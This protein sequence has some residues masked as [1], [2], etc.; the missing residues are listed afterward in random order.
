MGGT[1]AQ[2][3]VRSSA[4]RAPWRTGS[5]SASAAGPLLQVGLAGARPLLGGGV[6][7]AAAGPGPRS[8]GFDPD[9]YELDPEDIYDPDEYEHGFAAE[10]SAPR[11]Q[12][13]AAVAAAASA[14]VQPLAAAVAASLGGALDGYEPDDDSSAADAAVEGEAAQQG[15]RRRRHPRDH[16]SRGARMLLLVGPSLHRLACRLQ[17]AVV[18]TCKATWQLGGEALQGV[19]SSLGRTQQD[20]A[21]GFA[22]R[23]ARNRL[24]AHPVFSCSAVLTAG[25]AAAEV[26]HG[27]AVCVLDAWLQFVNSVAVPGLL[28]DQVVA[29]RPAVLQPGGQEG[30]GVAQAAGGGA[31]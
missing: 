11:P 4:G 2:L 28:L 16:L 6:P 26:C 1:K 22:D 13:T 7:R 25:Q 20:A 21:K 8:R 27:C 19:R 31:E 18:A 24:K 12:P 23:W 30:A 29:P 14:A 3:R 5:L 10:G 17:T 15:R 9:A